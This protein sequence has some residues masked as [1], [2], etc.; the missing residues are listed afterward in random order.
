MPL[1]P[2]RAHACAID[3]PCARTRTHTDQGTR[4]AATVLPSSGDRAPYPSP[5]ATVTIGRGGGETGLLSSRM[6]ARACS[7]VSALPTQNQ[8]DPP[9]ETAPPILPLGCP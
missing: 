6:S 9:R 5:R 7:F 1:T 8:S 3:T 2:T 4:V